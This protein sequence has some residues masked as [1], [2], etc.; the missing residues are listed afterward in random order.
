MSI[1][2]IVSALAAIEIDPDVFSV[3]IDGRKWRVQVASD[4]FTEAFPQH[5]IKR[6][7][8]FHDELYFDLENVTVFALRQKSEVAA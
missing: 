1:Y 3:Y 4:A 7:S 2:R 6:H 8:A 5:E